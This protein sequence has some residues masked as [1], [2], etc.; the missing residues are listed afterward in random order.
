[1]SIKPILF[2]TEMVRAILDG[3]KTQTRRVVK[4]L[5]GLSFYRAEPSEDA[6]EALGKW[7][8][9][10]GWLEGGV[11][12][13]ACVSVKAPCSIGDI[14]WVRETWG[15]LTECDV[16]PPYEPNEERFIY[17]ADIGDP[18]HFQAKWHP[19]IH[20]PRDAARI[21][22]R[23]KDVRVE[24]LQEITPE[25]A[26]AEGCDG[27]CNCPSSGG[28]GSLS[29]VER[30]FRVEKFESVWDS[31]IKRSDL[32]LYGWYANPWVW[33]ITFERC[34]RPSGWYEVL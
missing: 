20:M 25:Q 21:F 8:F 12:F 34:E 30:D 23:V 15:K 19:S 2:N 4:S 28:N 10:Y 1:M 14:L 31:T 26:R 29:C 3:R 6:Y 18:D 27:R 16:F 24:R 32:P 5:D 22:L 7:D 33:V 9:F 17:R 11:M 13:D